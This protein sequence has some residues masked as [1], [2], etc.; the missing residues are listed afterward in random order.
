MRSGLNIIP[1]LG[2]Y[3]DEE[4]KLRTSKQV[5]TNKYLINEKPTLSKIQSIPRSKLF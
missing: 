2:I 4:N 3:S 5:A 1:L